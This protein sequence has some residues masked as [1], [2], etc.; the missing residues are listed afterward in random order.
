MDNL[1]DPI[2]LILALAGLFQW[3]DNRNR[4]HHLEGTLSAVLKMSNRMSKAESSNDAVKQQALDITD[5][6][7]GA[8]KSVRSAPWSLFSSFRNHRRKGGE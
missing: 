5:S 6:L 7:N 4:A 2:N 8:I 3:L 1:L